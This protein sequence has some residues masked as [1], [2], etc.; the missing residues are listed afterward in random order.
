MKLQWSLFLSYWKY[1]ALVVSS[2]EDC[3][4][5]E[6]ALKHTHFLRALLLQIQIQCFWL[7]LGAISGP[8]L[9]TISWHLPCSFWNWVDLLYWVPIMSSL[10]VDVG[11]ADGLVS[12]ALN[13]PGNLTSRIPD[14]SVDRGSYC[15]TTTAVLQH[16]QSVPNS[17]LRAG[18]RSMRSITTYGH[19][20]ECCF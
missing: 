8:R 12:L 19:L 10:H 14:C 18:I 17:D 4:M 13:L 15:R 6:K 9:C 5:S 7:L 3:S 11:R 16:L 20:L 1:G 2:S